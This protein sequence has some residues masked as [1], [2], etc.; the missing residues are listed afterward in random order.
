MVVV[1]RQGLCEEVRDVLGAGDVG[2]LELALLDAVPDPV[3]PVPLP[4]AVRAS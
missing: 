4:R 3:E 2:Q 1:R